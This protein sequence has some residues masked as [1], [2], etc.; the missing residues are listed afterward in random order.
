MEYIPYH[1]AA[2]HTELTYARDKLAQA[3]F[4]TDDLGMIARAIYGDLQD[5]SLDKMEMELAELGYRWSATI[6]KEL[7]DAIRRR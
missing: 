2:L 1:M 4:E 5:M 6:P 7:E 3:G